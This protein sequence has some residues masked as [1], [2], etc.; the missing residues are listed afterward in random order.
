MSSLLG[1]V[2]YPVERRL[3]YN[4]SARCVSFARAAPFHTVGPGVVEVPVNTALVL[5]GAVCACFIV[6]LAACLCCHHRK[7]RRRRRHL[8]RRLRRSSS[9]LAGGGSSRLGALAAAGPPGPGASFRS[10][11]SGIGVLGVGSSSGHHMCDALG[12]R[13]AT[14]DSV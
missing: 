6:V 7:R 3:C 14:V 8:A 11:S 1:V 10:T 2:T 5:G 9:S 13:F 12:E 4:V